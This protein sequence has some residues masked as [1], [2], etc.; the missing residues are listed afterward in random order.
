[1]ASGEAHRKAHTA[2][3]VEIKPGSEDWEGRT[4]WDANSRS[5]PGSGK[6]NLGQGASERVLLIGTRLHGRHIASGLEAA[7]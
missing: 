2:R 3:G 4:G 1:M 7:R 6:T 5:T